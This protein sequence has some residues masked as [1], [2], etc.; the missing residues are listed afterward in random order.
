M[1]MSLST[2]I[3]NIILAPIIAYVVGGFYYGLYRT[4]SARIHGRWGP[5]LWQNF[6][7]NVKFF[8]KKEAIGHGLMF[9]LGPVI[10][11]AGSMTVILFLPFFREGDFLTGFSAHADIM[12]L[13]YLMVVGPLGNAL[14]VGVSGNPYGAMG[15]A[16]G[17]TRLMGLEVPFY[18]A[19]ATVMIGQ[20]TTSLTEVMAAQTSFG[21]WNAVK[22]PFAFLAS[23]VSFLGFMGASPFDV[24]GAPTE[25]YSGPR[26]EF[27]GKYLGILM[28]QRIIFS[29]AKLL[30]WVNVFLGGAYGFGDLL[31]K[32]FSLFLV[33]IFVGAVFPRFKTEQAVD[34][35]WKTTAVLSVFVLVF[36]SWRGLVW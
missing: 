36:Y 35:L 23:M 10:M 33:V 27:N 7:D 22:Y 2:M 11:A 4:I 14:A 13:T 20:G 8:A 26:A 12:L 9:H 3:I 16:R 21:E 1:T 15:V 32:S 30:F 6:V 18:L 34:A 28:V 5:P 17:L 29:F 25:V 24:V 19:L 31:L